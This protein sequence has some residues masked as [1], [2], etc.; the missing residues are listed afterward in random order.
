MSRTLLVCSVLLALQAAGMQWWYTQK[1][2]G[3]EPASC[4]LGVPAA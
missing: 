3:M 1:I 4:E 2:A